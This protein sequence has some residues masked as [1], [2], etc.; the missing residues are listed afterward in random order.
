MFPTEDT[1]EKISGAWCC[2]W[3]ASVSTF[4]WTCVSA[5]P[6]WPTALDLCVDTKRLRG[7]KASDSYYQRFTV[8]IHYTNTDVQHPSLVLQAACLLAII[9][10]GLISKAKSTCNQYPQLY[11]TVDLWLPFSPAHLTTVHEEQSWQM[12]SREIWWKLTDHNVLLTL[13]VYN[14]PLDV[15]I[16]NPSP[17]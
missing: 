6:H 11:R 9:S 2:Q 13:A 16:H 14:P 8:G 4:A 1:L 7:C 17:C 12:V 3:E 10:R 15:L 5:S